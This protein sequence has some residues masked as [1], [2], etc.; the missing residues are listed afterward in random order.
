MGLKIHSL[1]ELPL[2]I[3]MTGPAKNVTRF[4]QTLPLRSDEIKTAGLPESTT[5]KP[6]CSSRSETLSSSHPWQPCDTE[7][8]PGHCVRKFHHQHIPERAPVTSPFP[9]RAHRVFP[10][11]SCSYF[12]PLSSSLSL[13][14]Q[15]QKTFVF[16]GARTARR[17]CARHIPCRAGCIRKFACGLMT[18]RTDEG[19]RRIFLNPGLLFESKNGRNRPAFARV[20]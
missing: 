10:L 20:V 7:A 11:P 13:P 3:E 1:A 14:N 19:K 17:V 8:S 2:Q 6:A 16:A 9:A 4:L 15:T 5:N 12:P 18:C